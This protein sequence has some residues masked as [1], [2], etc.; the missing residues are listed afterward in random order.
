[1]AEAVR[2]ELAREVDGKDLV[3][4]LRAGGFAAELVPIDDRF[5]VDV[6]YRNDEH[7]RLQADA[8]KAVESWLAEREP[9]LVPTP[10]GGDLYVLSPPAE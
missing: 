6:A 1:M 4:F 2:F 5:E 8:W 9:M 7:A 3:E 10:V